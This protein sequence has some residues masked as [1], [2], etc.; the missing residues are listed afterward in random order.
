MK[1]PIVLENASETRAALDV[2]TS[3]AKDEASEP[4][5]Y[6]SANRAHSQTH[7]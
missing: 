3:A 2:G 5:D 7:S 1:Q 4:H 6:I